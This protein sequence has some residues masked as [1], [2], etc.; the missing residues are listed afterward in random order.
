MWKHYFPIIIN[1]SKTAV[2]NKYK[3]IIHLDFQL[4]KLLNV[5]N[6]LCLGSEGCFSGVDLTVIAMLRTTIKLNSNGWFCL[7]CFA[8]FLLTT[9]IHRDGAQCGLK[10]LL[11]LLSVVLKGILMSRFVIVHSNKLGMRKSTRCK[12]LQKYLG[13]C[14]YKIELVHELKPLDHRARD[15]WA[16]NQIAL[17]P[18]FKSKILF[19]D[20]AHFWLSGY[21]NMLIHKSMQIYH[22]LWTRNSKFVV[23]L[24]EYAPSYWKK[25]LKTGLPTNKLWGP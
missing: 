6:A 20:E 15:E 11:V 2:S 5:R 25:C 3:T 4:I 9:N 22:R 24:P 16:E 23:L 7:F 8:I 21:R 18:A 12:I 17:D 19:I 10:M 1:K 14:A 13:L